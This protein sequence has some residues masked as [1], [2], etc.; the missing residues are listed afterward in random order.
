MKATSRLLVSSLLAGAVALV[1]SSAH[2]QSTRGAGY[3]QGNVLGFATA[4]GGSGFPIDLHGG[5]HLSG[6]GGHEGFVIGGTQ[7]FI[8]GGG[9]GFGMTMARLGFDIAIP[10]KDMELTIAPYGQGGIGYGFSGGDPGAAFGFG[11]DGRFFPLTEGAGKG[12]FATAKPFELTFLPT[13]LV[14]FTFYTFSVG[15]GYAF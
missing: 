14:T 5:I 8:F 1:S 3:I 15:A 13:S 4:S 11:V 10:I 6:N 2:A 12:F 9:G 7:K